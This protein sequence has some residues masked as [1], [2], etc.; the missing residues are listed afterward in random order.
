MPRAPG[1]AL[2]SGLRC[3]IQAL[4]QPAGRLA[5][6]ADHDRVPVHEI[7]PYPGVPLDPSSGRY[8][9]PDAAR[10][11]V[12]SRPAFCLRCQTPGVN[13][14]LA[15]DQGTTSS[16][17][18]LFDKSGSGIAVAQREFRQIFPEPGWVEHDP[19][20]IWNTQSS[21]MAEVIA[22][23]PKASVMAIGIANQRE[24]T[25]LWDRETGGPVANAIVWQDRRTA[26]LCDQL[27]ADG[28]EPMFRERTG[29]LLD[30]Y[31]SGTKI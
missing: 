4:T 29:L 7:R 21:V 18:M 22:Q 1:P 5:S 16:R 25:V 13:T 28:F 19:E 31:F 30:P 11:F 27:R 9:Q 24:T 10:R 15:V 6:R 23:V 3:Q 12:V 17:A 2:I 20:D 8:G 14:I 26:A